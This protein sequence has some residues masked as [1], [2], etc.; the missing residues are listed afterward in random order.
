[1]KDERG[2]SVDPSTVVS[3]PG[4][5]RGHRPS[6][7]H[8]HSPTH[9]TRK[10]TKKQVEPQFEE[11][12]EAEIAAMNAAAAAAMG[13]YRLS[14]VVYKGGHP[15]CGVLPFFRHRCFVLFWVRPPPWVRPA[16]VCLGLYTLYVCRP[17]GSFFP[18]S[19]LVSLD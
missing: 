14:S 8:Q 15:A 17:V 12:T 18:L 3:G 6:P 11:D 4:G 9:I 13:A 16:S 10:H 19:S 1:M 2:R 7:W 5:A